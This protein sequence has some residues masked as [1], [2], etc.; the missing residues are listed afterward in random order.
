MAEETKELITHDP[1]AFK[2]DGVGPKK[3]SAA[4]VEPTEVA[5]VSILP[6]AETKPVEEPKPTE[7]AKPIESAEPAPVDE[8]AKFL[9]LYNKKFKTSFKTIEEMDKANEKKPEPEVLTEDQKKEREEKRK[10]EALAWKIEQD[11]KFK[12]TYEKSISDKEKSNRDIALKVF[13]AKELA[14]DKTLTAND[15]EEMFKDEYAED[16]DPDSPRALRALDRMASVAENYRKENYSSVDKYETEYRDYKMFETKAKDYGKQTKEVVESLPKEL[17]FEFDFMDADGKPDKMQI[18]FA[19][20]DDD[21]KALRK[22]LQ[23]EDTF[24]AVKANLESVSNEKLS[25]L[26]ID[27]FW[28]KNRSNIIKAVGQKAIEWAE[29]EVTARYKKV[30]NTS[31]QSGQIALGDEGKKLITHGSEAFSGQAR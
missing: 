20:S 15:I 25:E 21:M 19:I 13:S 5:P 12:E 22:E 27:K 7:V 23:H 11:P 28:V 10:A 9:E 17:T 3:S 29:K 30:P 14:K 8:D 18:P 31:R 2:N 4:V 24:F 6:T 1:A 16:A 26:A